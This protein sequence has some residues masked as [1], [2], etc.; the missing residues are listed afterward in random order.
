MIVSFELETSGSDVPNCSDVQR[1]S[2]HSDVVS[3][4]IRDT[5]SH[6]IT[7]SVG[8]DS[9]ERLNMT[10]YNTGLLRRSYGELITLVDLCDESEF[11]LFKSITGYHNLDSMEDDTWSKC[12]DCGKEMTFY[13]IKEYLVE[14]MTRLL[15]MDSR[16][17]ISEICGDCLPYGLQHDEME[18]FRKEGVHSDTII[19]CEFGEL[20]DKVLS[21]YSPDSVDSSDFYYFM[22]NL[23]YDDD[24]WCEV[25]E[26]GEQVSESKC[27]DGD[28]DGVREE[29]DEFMCN[30]EYHKE[31]REYLYGIMKEENH[32]QV[33]MSMIEYHQNTL[34][35]VES[36]DSVVIN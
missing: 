1:L 21:H 14:R 9:I 24:H 31:F 17:P 35:R 32:P 16:V 27:D 5:E 36:D 30:P 13:D 33:L 28:E 6:E 19:V 29:F 15:G 7:G 10:L 25:I 12:E 26:L 3:T 23:F 34:T 22:W 18:F 2:L 8:D 4:S 11:G 20:R